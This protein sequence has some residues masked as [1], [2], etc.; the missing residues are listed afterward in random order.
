[1]TRPSIR[2][3]ALAYVLAIAICLTVV[4]PLH[5]SIHMAD[6]RITNITE[7]CLLGYQKVDNSSGWVVGKFKE[8][9]RRSLDDNA[10]LY[11]HIIALLIFFVLFYIFVH[12]RWEKF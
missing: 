12:L 3:I 9:E 8:G 11:S 10:Y 6:S 7:Y 5:E 1:M 4:I 2:R